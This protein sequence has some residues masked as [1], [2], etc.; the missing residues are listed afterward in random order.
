MLEGTKRAE[1][2]QLTSQGLVR[3]VDH[4]IKAR[5]LSKDRYP[6]QHWQEDTGPINTV[7]EGS[8]PFRVSEP[9]QAQEHQPLWTKWNRTFPPL[10]LSRHKWLLWKEV[11][12]QHLTNSSG[13]LSKQLSSTFKTPSWPQKDTLWLDK[14]AFNGKIGVFQKHKLSNK[15]LLGSLLS[16]LIRLLHVFL[17]MLWLKVPY[18]NLNP[19]LVLTWKPVEQQH[20]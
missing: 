11:F 13:N 12:L 9:F 16:A 3:P 15:S 19:S 10:F 20:I 18:Y 14:E 8:V 4:W 1:A 7:Y 6:S 5:Q 2:S 17:L